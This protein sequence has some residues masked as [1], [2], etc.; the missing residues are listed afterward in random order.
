MCGS[1]GV[2]VQK[3]WV[4]GVVYLKESTKAKAQKVC[5]VSEV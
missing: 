1:V 3:D 5:R 4:F 2:L